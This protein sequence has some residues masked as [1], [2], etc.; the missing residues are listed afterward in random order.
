MSHLDT[1][2]ETKSRVSGR[3]PRPNPFQLSIGSN[4]KL[5]L[6]HGDT[7]AP[8]LVAH[9]HQAHSI[10]SNLFVSYAPA[11]EAG[12]LSPC[13]AQLKISHQRA[14]NQS[15][16]AQRVQ[17]TFLRGAKF[18]TRRLLSQLLE[19]IWL[20]LPFASSPGRKMTLFAP[21]FCAGCDW[22]PFEL[23]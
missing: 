16:R 7:P 20:V 17:R 8:M 22:W 9:F 15:I 5:V 14:I 23:F 3:D 21:L 19:V 10:G 1:S 11:R 4:S 18:E 2:I 13:L 12:G 6:L